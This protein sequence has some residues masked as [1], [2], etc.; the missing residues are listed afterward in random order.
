MFSLKRFSSKPAVSICLPVRNGEAFL[1]QALDSVLGQNFQDFELLIADD[2]STD[3]SPEIIK[4][5]VS[6]DER[7]TW[8]RNDTCLGLFANYNKCME[9]ASGIYIKPFAQDDLWAPELLTKQVNLLNEYDDVALVSTSRTLIDEYGEEILPEQETVVGILGAQLTYPSSPVIRVCLDHALNNLIGEP[10][11]VMFRKS[12]Q[13]IGFRTVFK[14]AGDL[15][16]W[17]R[18][19]KHGNF[20]MLNEPQRFSVNTAGAPAVLIP[21]SS[22]HTAISYICPTLPEMSWLKWGSR[23]SSS[24]S[25]I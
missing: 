1:Q 18:I 8:W 16:Y 4:Q 10:C 11:A 2:C 25:V 13:D 24:S 7:I 22:G 23:K 9:Q 17:L 5:Y 12:L 21:N 14:H 6:Q 15:E 3:S 19:L 20:G